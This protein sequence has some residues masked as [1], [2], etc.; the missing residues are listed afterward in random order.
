MTLSKY[1][2]ENHDLLGIDDKIKAELP[3][4]KLIKLNEYEVKF[5]KQLRLLAYQIQKI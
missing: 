2:K 1:I 4:S 5:H 3:E